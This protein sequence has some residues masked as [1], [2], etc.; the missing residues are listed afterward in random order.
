MTRLLLVTASSVA[1]ILF[2]AFIA[3]RLLRS[4]TAGLSIRMQIFLALAGIVGTFAFGLGV[5][6]IDRVKA[7]ATLLAEESA[8]SEATTVAA[9]IGSEVG[10]KGKTLEEVARDL[11]GVEDSLPLAVL[12]P[13]GATVVAFGPQ[14]RPD[15]TANVAVT[16]PIT[17]DGRRLGDVRVV[18]QT[19]AI[20][21]VLAD[22]APAVLLISVV[23]G[24]A[25]AIAAAMIGR[26]IASPIENLTEF[27]ERVSEGDLR[28]KPPAAHGREVMR[29]TSAIDTMRRELEG[30]PFVEAFAADL[31]HELKN[32]VAA[33]RASAEVL[34]EGA[35][36]E[37]EQ[38]RRF[39][40]RIRE[41]VDRIERLLR[42]LLHLARMEAGGV[43][44]LE[45]LDLV[46]LVQSCVDLL[47]ARAR[48]VFGE[49]TPVKIQGEPTWLSRAIGNLL[50]NALLHSTPGSPVHVSVLARDGQAH[51]VVRSQGQL[52]RYVRENVFRRFITTRED[53]GGSGLGLAI[54]RAVAEAHGGQA[55]LGEPG[56]PEVVFALSIPALRGIFPMPGLGPKTGAARLSN[57][58]GSAVG[59][60]VPHASGTAL[61][62][63]PASDAATPMPREGHETSRKGAVPHGG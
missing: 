28:A 54:V 12:A 35:L 1:L 61:A 50:D 4:R 18:K 43:E 25:A 16:V 51:V 26:T 40:A 47:P 31:S 33:I 44:G 9:L 10:K 7:R 27:A 14:L 3:A 2:V 48:I 8:R 13:D 39:V 59:S 46:V 57:R 15:D 19:I 62:P 53:K 49:L 56:P 34:E 36:A 37:P 32:P 45:T 41:A 23:L 38:A 55:L 20:E 29:L 11:A 22:L 24:A 6:V 21:R 17:A 30:R 58:N 60:A 5:L 42:D 63:A 52:S